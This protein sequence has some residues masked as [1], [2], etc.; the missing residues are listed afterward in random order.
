MNTPTKEE[1]IQDMKKSFQETIDWINEQ[2]ESRFNEEILEGK[3]TIA[4]HL[5]HLIK[6]TKAVTQGM[7]MPKLGLRMSFGKNNRPE[8][9]YQETLEK[10]ESVL[11]TNPGIRPPGSFEAEA[12]RTFERSA[13]TARFEKE[14][15]A[16][17]KALGKWKEK[18]MSVYIMPH[19]AIGKCTIREFVYFTIFHTNHHLATL[20][21]KYVVS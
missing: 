4:G 21:E 20:K 8:R 7:K 10:Y 9:S 3:W 16:M 13:L 17:I 2:P 14:L 12:G 5:Y 6:S 15:E 1:L 18:D 19:P 11:T